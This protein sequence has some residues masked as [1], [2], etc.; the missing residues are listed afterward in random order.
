VKLHHV[1]A[2]SLSSLA[3]TFCQPQIGTRAVTQTRTIL[4][5]FAGFN[6]PNTLGLPCASPCFSLPAGT[7]IVQPNH[8][9]S[10]NSLGLYYAVYQANGWTGDLN[11]T[12]TLSEAGEVVQTVTAAGSITSDQ[13]NSPSVISVNSTIPQNA[14]VGPA[15]LIATTTA[16]PGDGSPPFT[17]KSSSVMEVGGMGTRRVI[18]LFAGI[19]TGNGGTYPCAASQCNTGL[20]PG[21]VAVQPAQFQSPRIGGIFY[22]AFQVDGWYGEIG[23]TAVATQ[24]KQ[25]YLSVPVGGSVGNGQEAYSAVLFSADGY[26]Q[27][28]DAKPGPALL[29]VTTTAT[30]R[31][32]NQFNLKS[33]A[34]IWVQ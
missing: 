25:T 31:S 10:S 26:S 34:P 1:F 12:F 6:Q 3:V 19:S 27:D 20:P 23:G 29:T 14:F 8:F 7:V 22:A 28:N 21:S 18:P 13:A 5:A 30:Q 33:T 9:V 17:M 32:G 11:I 2:A 15:T 24:G 16:I 4:Q